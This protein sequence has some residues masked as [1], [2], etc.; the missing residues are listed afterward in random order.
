MNWA[1]A[2]TT[3]D[4]FRAAGDRAAN[5]WFKEYWYKAAEELGQKYL[6]GQPWLRTYDGKLK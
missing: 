3:I 5:Q 2:L 6:V 1:Q 4:K